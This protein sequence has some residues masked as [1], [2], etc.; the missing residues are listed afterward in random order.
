MQE[1]WEGASTTWRWLLE[2]EK[3][4]LGDDHPMVLGTYAKLAKCA[5]RLDKVDEAA[6]RRKQE[7]KVLPLALERMQLL[8]DAIDFKQEEESKGFFALSVNEGI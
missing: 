3:T 1:D 7:R 4:E 6:K 5:D 8:A 2:V